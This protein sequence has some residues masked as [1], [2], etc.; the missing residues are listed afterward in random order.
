[1]HLQ[2]DKWLEGHLL[3][4]RFSQPLVVLVPGLDI[5]FT[6]SRSRIRD[7]PDVAQV[8]LFEHIENNQFAHFTV[9]NIRD[10][11][12][13]ALLCKAMPFIAFRDTDRD[14]VQDFLAYVLGVELDV[15][16]RD[17]LLT[18][19]IA[20]TKE[21][22]D[23]MREQAERESTAAQIP[24]VTRPAEEQPN[25][26]VQMLTAALGDSSSAVLSAVRGLH[27]NIRSASGGISKMVS[28]L[29]RREHRRAAQEFETQE[30]LQW[31]GRHL[32]TRVESGM[33]TGDED[34]ADE[35]TD[36]ELKTRVDDLQTM[37]RER[38]VKSAVKQ[39]LIEN[40]VAL[41]QAFSATG[42]PVETTT[43]VGV[44]RPGPADPDPSSGSYGE[45]FAKRMQEELRKIDARKAA[46][47]K[48]IEDSHEGD[49]PEPSA[50]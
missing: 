24:G 30:F 38:K 3:F 47:L 25:L 23:K 13:W 4:I 11:R 45:G 1:M 10:Q 32:D 34:P 29:L 43:S 17:R 2:L 41:V 46:D 19:S 6:L 15:I 33:F 44:T 18:E 31:I 22:Q 42:V 37:Q 26:A 35:Y 20:K 21:F 16:R 27:E 12:G 39:G 8:E 7:L 14:E 49:P 50:G 9:E 48:K 36:E 5:A 28:Y 40:I